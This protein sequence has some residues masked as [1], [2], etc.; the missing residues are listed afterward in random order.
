MGQNW[1][2]VQTTQSM[3]HL[4]MLLLRQNLESIPIGQL[5]IAYF[6][7]RSSTFLLEYFVRTFRWKKK[8]KVLL[9]LSNFPPPFFSLL[10]CE[11]LVSP[12]LL[13]HVMM[14]HE[15]KTKVSFF[16]PRGIYLSSR[17]C[18]FRSAV[19]C[20]SPSPQ[21]HSFSRYRMPIDRYYFSSVATQFW[22]FTGS[23][24]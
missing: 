20:W 3:K 4:K 12:P 19:E 14:R 23:A 1:C 17:W 22:D 16:V 18:V 6:L 24:Q 13:S 8:S 15:T 21:Q 11:L 7:K 2:K 10:R 5:A 9:F